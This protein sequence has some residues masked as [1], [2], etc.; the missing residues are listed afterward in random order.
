MEA[1]PTLPIITRE[2]GFNLSPDKPTNGLY[3]AVIAVNDDI[4]DGRPVDLKR[5][6]L[7]AYKA[8]P[9]VLYGH[10]RW[11]PNAVIGR[12]V[13]LQ[14]TPRGLEA[15][16]EFDKTSVA[17]EI[18]G[19]WERGFLRAVSIG[20]RPMADNPNRHELVE[21]S[22]VPVPADRDAIRDVTAALLSRADPELITG[23]VVMMNRDGGLDTS[24]SN[25]PRLPSP[26]QEAAMNEEQIRAMLQEIMR[27]QGDK[28]DVEGIVRA[29]A[30]K[31]G[32]MVTADQLKD[33]IAEAVQTAETKR[34]EAED[35]AKAA[36]EQE[37][38]TKRQADKAK[39]DE[40]DR[41]R[42][43]EENAETRANLI[44]MVRELLPQDYET[45]GKTVKE[46]LVAAVGD[47]VEKADERDEQYLFAKIEGLIE[48]REA[49]RKGTQP[50]PGPGPGPAPKDRPINGDSGT[51][52]GRAAINVLSLPGRPT[53]ETLRKDLRPTG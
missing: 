27:G 34:Q 20:A 5:M 14:W 43:A 8:N 22:I 17:E 12:T 40:A 45:K 29:L 52:V 6:S 30:D 41:I 13:A 51:H 35:Q 24:P 46:I 11:S 2:A 53:P 48:Q 36:R 50:P 37:E 26:S 44:V 18:K 31:F 4:G 28:P 32:N 1:M 19:S 38:E 23:R 10:D 49:A 25:V 7:E 39:E 3:N 15:S 16:F 42:K 47:T 33:A 9:I 21:W